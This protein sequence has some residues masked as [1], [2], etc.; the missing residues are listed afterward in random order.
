MNRIK[1]NGRRYNY[2]GTKKY[3]GVAAEMQL[4]F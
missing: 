3:V 4:L 1:Y 2:I